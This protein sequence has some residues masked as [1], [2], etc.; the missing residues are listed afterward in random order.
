MIIKYNN[1][2]VTKSHKWCSNTGATPIPPGPEPEQPT[3]LYPKNTS[4]VNSLTLNN[5]PTITQRYGVVNFDAKVDLPPENV[6]V[7]SVMGLIRADIKFWMNIA[8]S[9]YSTI[10]HRWEPKVTFASVS[11]DASYYASKFIT[12]SPTSGLGTSMTQIGVGANLVF[13]SY[14]ND[15][16][17][18]NSYID[19]YHSADR[20]TRFK[21]VFDRNTNTVYQYLN[22]TLIGTG[23]LE[24]TGDV[25]LG[26]YNNGADPSNPP[27]INGGRVGTIKNVEIVSF[28]D[29]EAAAA[30]YG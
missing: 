16:Y 14:K 9:H 18:V 2:I 25:F 8:D 6:E 23:T 5:L 13:D 29:F 21:L 3:I 15:T 11:Q 12:F 10:T 20:Y 7:T 22:N 17:F 26:W 27:H 1:K 28:D 24:G 30:Y 4:V 19:D